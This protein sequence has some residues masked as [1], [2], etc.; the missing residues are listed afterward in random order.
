MKTISQKEIAGY[1][2]VSQQFICDIKKKR[3]TFGKKNA[4]RIFKLTGI[5]L[6]ELTFEKGEELL[7]KFRSAYSRRGEK[8]K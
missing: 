4:I 2:G 7:E 6:E 3:R 5:P 1:V 8:A